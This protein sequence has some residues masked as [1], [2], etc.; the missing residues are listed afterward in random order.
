M[1][2]NG[3]GQAASGFCHQYCIVTRN[4]FN[5]LGTDVDHKHYADCWLGPYCCIHCKDCWQVGNPS[6]IIIKFCYQTN[7]IAKI[8]GLSVAVK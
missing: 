1:Q 5:V 7:I 4:C 2:D 6:D 3:K 8:Q